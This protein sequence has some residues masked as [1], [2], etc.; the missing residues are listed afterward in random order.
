MSQPQMKLEA[1]SQSEPGAASSVAALFPGQGS[2]HVGMLRE[3]HGSFKVARE[4]FEEASDA[5][6]E[7]LAGLCFNGPE[8]ALLLTENTQP[9]LLAASV[10]AFRV[11]TSE[12]GL[13]PDF[14]AGHSLGE[15]SALV[16]AGSLGLGTATR[17]V[18]ERG[19]A[20]Q[21]AVPAGQGMMA[22]VLNMDDERIRKLCEVATDSARRKREAGES[23][24]LHVEPVVE[25]ANFNA[26]GQI[27][28]A[29]AADAVTEAIS[30]IKAGGD[31]VGGKAIPLPV[32]APFHC[33]LMAPARS[34]MAEIFSSATDADRPA[35]LTIPY[36]PNRTARITWETGLIFEFLIE[37]VDHPVL[38]KQ[39]IE[40]LLKAGVGSVV[41]FGPGKVLTGL[42]K[43]ISQP[44]GKT[45]TLF[46]MNES[47]HLK[48]LETAYRRV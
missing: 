35:S 29:G 17:W 31:F 36:V 22:A 11:A 40:T 47:S 7:D 43:R 26:P 27:V 9:C 33:R 8:S 44:I 21:M 1:I 39:S 5:I 6:H 37:Q 4:V 25:P 14:V 2:Q 48:A 46:Q 24:E 28:I 30:L 15:Y 45:P 3:L 18:R 10:A 12:L 23:P 13:R 34:R 16:A 20:M 38:W 32:S 41:E 42:V 19:I